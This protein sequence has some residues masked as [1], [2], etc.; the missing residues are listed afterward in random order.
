M[1]VSLP[2]YDRPELHGAFDRLWAA[3]RQELK[4]GPVELSRDSNVWQDWVS[5]DL[6]LSQTCGL[7]FRAKLHDKVALVGTP[8]HGL[9]LS[10]SGYYCSV[11]VAHKDDPRTAPIEYANAVLAY[12]EPMS[13]SGWAAAEA[14]ARDNGFAFTRFVQTGSHA[15]SAKTVA[16]M[17]ADIAALDVVSWKLIQR[18]ESFAE[19]LRVIGHTEQTPAL[20]FITA[21]NCDPTKIFD[22]IA[23]AIA[24]LS[25]EDRDTLCLQGVVKTTPEEYL[26]IPLP[27][28]SPC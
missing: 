23:N 9:A 8:D 6:L 16:E 11:F 24:R 14:Y 19:K 5:R 17:S 4:T 7:P 28:S 3:I 26:A 12:N 18:Y 2:M 21:K 22:A 1:I 10:N 25:Q 15:A 27:L 20:P 13:Q